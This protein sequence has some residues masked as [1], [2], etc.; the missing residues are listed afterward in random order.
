LIIDCPS[1]VKARIVAN[2]NEPIFLSQ[3]FAIDLLI[4]E[5]CALWRETFINQHYD[6]IF[7]WVSILPT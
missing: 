1:N 5:E 2:A 6:Q 7:D 4:V 3:P